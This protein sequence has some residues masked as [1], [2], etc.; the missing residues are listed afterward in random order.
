MGRNVLAYTPYFLLA[1]VVSIFE[2]NYYSKKRHETEFLGSRDLKTDG[3]SV[4]KSM[5]ILSLY[6]RQEQVNICVTHVS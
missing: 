5:N 3:Y 2:K 6:C 1:L 4:R